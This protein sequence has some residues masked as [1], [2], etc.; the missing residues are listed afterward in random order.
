MHAAPGKGVQ[1]ASDLDLDPEASSWREGGMEGERPA[2]STHLP[3][4]LAQLV[5]QRLLLALLRSGHR[6]QA[7]PEP[8][9]AD[10][11]QA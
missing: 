1:A 11:N 10:V 2:A 4:G 3:H 6:F 9:G 5:V 8:P 7:D